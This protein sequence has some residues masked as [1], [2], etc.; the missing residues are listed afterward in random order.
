MP[1]YTPG[2]VQMKT[3]TTGSGPY[4]LTNPSPALAGKR[5][6]AE[7]VADGS[8]VYGQEVEIAIVDPTAA[9]S[10]K[11]IETFVGTISASL[12][13]TV[14]TPLEKS[15]ALVSGGGWGAGNRDVLISPPYGTH[16]AFVDLANIFLAT[17]TIDGASPTLNYRSGGDVRMRDLYSASVGYRQYFNASAVIRAAMELQDAAAILKHYNT[18]GMLDGQLEVGAGTLQFND[19]T[20]TRKVVRFVGGGAVKLTFNCAPPTGWTRINIMGERI[21]KYATASDT[22]EATG[23]SWT[24][25]GLTTPLSVTDDYVLTIADLP[26]HVHSV[27]VFSGGVG[28]FFQPKGTVEST[29]VGVDD[30]A[31]AGGGEGHNHNIPVITI[32]SN[33]VWRPAYEIVVKASLD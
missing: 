10:A 25:S 17:Q 5:T 23:G 6:I 28:G 22:P 1:R 4:T 27:E 2:R 7:A 3:A 33:G 18:S 30:S 20:T 32:Q 16:T 14:V 24:I 19:G 12:I 11:L 9:G 21:A 13:L 8:Y 29:S 15:A 31:S 26:P